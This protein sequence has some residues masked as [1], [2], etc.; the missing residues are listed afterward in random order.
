MA[1]SLIQNALQV[2]FDSVLSCPEEC[3]V[4]MFKYL[5]STGLRGFLGCP[6]VIYEQYL[7]S[8]F[9]NATV[10]GDSVIR[11]VQRKFVGIS[12]ELFAGAF[13]LLTE[14]MTS[15]DE[16]PKDL[17]YDGPSVFSASGEPVKT[18]CKNKEIIEFRLLNDIL[19]KSVIVKAG[20]SDAVTQE[21]FLLMTAIHCVLKINW[22]KI[23]FD[24][25]KDMVISLSK[26]AKGFAAQICGLLKGAPDLTLGE[27]KTFTPL[28]ILTV[29]TVGTYVAKNKTITADEE[30]ADEP[31]MEKVVNS[32]GYRSLVEMQV[33]VSCTS[34]FLQEE[35]AAAEAF[36]GCVCAYSSSQSKIWILESLTPPNSRLLTDLEMAFAHAST[37]KERVFRNKIFDFQQEIKTQKSAL[38]QDLNDFRMET[39]EGINTL[40]TK[41]SEIIAYINKG[42]DDKKG[43]ESSRGPPP[44]DRSRPGSGSSRPG[45]GG[46][47]SEPPK[48]GG[49]S[50]RGGASRSSRGFRLVWMSSSSF[51][52][53]S[54]T[55]LLYLAVRS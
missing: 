13:G 50:N 29:K 5:E 44:D 43:E 2:N 9:S 38:S 54:C 11:S 55:K 53:S 21:Q 7:E 14:G 25:I 10:H 22:S 36:C 23:L 30:V 52:F 47:R 3:M 27:A 6:S 34:Y 26:Q 15:M 20:S 1:A 12:K 24:I 32:R 40:S 28:K 19:E 48:R 17:I 42:R 51:F 4:A 16:V 41:F 46:S 39:Q 37:H 33:Q 31:Q 49:G 35:A 8:F 18:S 45:E